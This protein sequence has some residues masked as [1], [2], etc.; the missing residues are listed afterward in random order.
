MDVPQS[1]EAAAAVVVEPAAEE[2][3]PK[4]VAAERL[5]FFADAVIAIAMTL[6]ALDLFAPKG[7]EDT[8]NSALLDLMWRNRETYIG[9]LISFYVIG[10]H[11]SSHHRIFRYVTRIGG[12]LTLFSLL[13]LFTL[14]VTPFATR[15]LTGEGAF[16]VRFILYAVVQALSGVFFL[17]MVREI[18]ANR[19]YRADIPPDKFSNA[20]FGSGALAA[21]FLASVPV[22]FYTTNA[23]DCWIVLPIVTALARR[24]YQRR[25]AARAKAAGRGAA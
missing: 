1:S 12:R 23:Y 25:I 17:L 15:M 18:Q 21:G 11:W 10:T 5:T 4:A 8:T 16:Q 20:Y 2:P 7:T 22:S 6:L 9:F 3:D 19:L 13:W 14:V 24:H